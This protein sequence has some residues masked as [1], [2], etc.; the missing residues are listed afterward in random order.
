MQRQQGP[1]RNH[2]AGLQQARPQTQ[3]HKHRK[4]IHFQPSS[5]KKASH[6]SPKRIAQ[7]G[8]AV[9]A[10]AAPTVPIAISSQSM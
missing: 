6:R 7:M 3:Y 9:P 1:L 8:R 5:R 10:P 4:C 2:D